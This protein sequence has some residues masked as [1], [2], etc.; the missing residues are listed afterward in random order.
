MKTGVTINYLR[1]Q[2]DPQTTQ[3]CRFYDLQ[4]FLTVQCRFCHAVMFTVILAVKAN[5]EKLLIR[6]FSK[7]FISCESRYHQECRSQYTRKVVWMKKVFFSSFLFTLVEKRSLV[8]LKS[9]FANNYFSCQAHE[10]WSHN[11]LFEMPARSPN[12]STVP[13]LWPTNI[14]NRPVPILSCGNVHSYP[15]S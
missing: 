7:A 9:G 8:H 2:P 13:I 12:N 6:S 14:L 10:N 4:I 5:E 1:C 15:S 11:Q 3:Q